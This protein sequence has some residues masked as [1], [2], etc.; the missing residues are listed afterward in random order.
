MADL[1]GGVLSCKSIGE[2]VRFIRAVSTRRQQ[3]PFGVEKVEGKSYDRLRREANERAISLLNSLADGAELTDEQRQTLAGYTGEGGI[4][5]SVSEYYTPKPVAEGVWEIMKLYGADVGNTLE[6]SAGTGVFNET[7]PVGTVMTATEISQI[8]GRINQL[9]HPEDSVQ[10][11]PFEQLATS[12]PNDSF[13]HVVGNVPF[14]GRDNT[15]NLDKP[16]AEE[17]DMG[18]YFMLRML[19]KIKPGGFMCVIV[20]PSIVSGNNMKR[21]R[22]RLSRKA[23]FLGAHRLPTGTF[24]ANGTSTVVDV[25]LM[26]KHP[27]D[28]A[29][30]IAQAEENTLEAANV[31]WSTFITGKWFERDG[32]RFVH[33]TQEQGFQGRIEVRA[34]GQIDN[35]ALKAKL[36]HRFDS[37]ID[38]SMLDVDEPSPTA[39]VIDDG[40]MRLINGVW[41]KFAGGH[42]IEADAGKELVI[43]S[44]SY[45]ADSWEAL[46][47]NLTTAE[48]RLA[49]TFSQMA[50]VRQQYTNSLSEDMVQLVDWIDSQPEKFRERLYRGAMIGRMLI[51]YQDM[52]AAGYSPTDIEQRRLSLVSKLQAEIDRFG[53]PGRGSIAKLSGSGARAWFAFRG[54]IKLDGSISDELTG[55]LITHD[56]SASYDSTSHQDTLRHLYSDLTRDPIQLDDFRQAFT[57]DLPASDDELLDLLANTPGI[58]VSPYGGIVPFA[59][60]TSGDISEIVAP[61]L[62]FLSKLPDGAVKNNV[63]NQ[64][65]AIEEKRIKTPAENIRF[66]LNSR[67]FDRSVILEFLKDNGYP[68]L[69]YVQSVQL[70]GDEMIS[71]TYHGGDG[72]FV[73]HRYGVVQRKD[74]ETGEIRYEWD[75]KSGDNATG[76][77]AQLEKY[78]N[79]ARIG[80]KDGATANGYREQMALLEDQFNKWIKTHDRYDDLVAKY[81]EVF[82]SNIPYEHSGDSLE[83][84]GISGKRQPFDYQN[85]E[86]R[87]LSEDGR[88][89]LGFGTGLGKTTTA[90]ALEAFNFENGRSTRTAYVVPK[91]VLEN[92]YYETKEFLSEQAFNNYLFI[93]LDVLMDGDQIRQVPVLD[94]NGKQVIGDDG[95]PVMRDGLKLADEAT[96]T[97]RMNA[98]PHSNYRAVV[99]TKEQYAR[100]PL[101][102]ETVDEHAEDMLYDF[103]AAG[104]VASAMESDS[105][106]KE[107][108]RRRVL[109]EHS[110]TG[111]EKA[112]K[113]PYFED[114]GFDSVIADEGHNY[115]NSYKNGREASQLAYLPTSAVAQS[116]R[117][118]AIKNAYLM[119]KNGGRGPVLL[120]A[121]PV[122]NTPIDA[123]NMLSHVLPKEFWQKMGI[124]GP[125]DFVKF[126]GKTRLE[127]VQK[128]SG[129]VEEKMAL[130]GFENLDA[131]RGIFHR[132]T[133]LKTAEDVKDTVEIP[134]LDERQQDAPLTDEQ[135]A[136]YEDLRK[137]AE[138]A[139]N[140]DKGMATIV[141]EDGT[142]TQE[143]TRPI[144]SIIR[145]MDRVCTDMDLYHRRITYRFL[146]EYADAVQ[147]LADDLP[148][149]A[150]SEDDDSTDSVTQQA[151]YSLIDKGDFIQL[152]VPEAFEPEVNKRLAKFGI[153]ERTVTH[154]ITPKYAKLIATLKE[155]LPDGKQIIFTDEKT[156]HQKLKRIICNALN[157]DPSQVGI[158]N[159]QTVADAGKSGKKLKAVKPPKDLPDEPT[160]A[161]LAKY[162]EQ[163][164]QYDA[165]IAQQNEISL[166]GLEKIAA[167]YQEGRTP[168]IICNKKAEVGINL[169]RG[170]SDIH[171]LTLPWTPASIAQRNGRGARVGSNR[172]SVRVHYYCGKGSF[173]EY[174]L[175]TLKRKAGWISDILR[176]DKSEMENADA[177][178]M[179]EM[180]MYTAKDDGERLSM[181]Q[182]QMDK[183]K[184]AQLAR[185]KEQANYDLQNYIKAQHAAGEDVEALTAE[186][187]KN[188][189]ALE[190]ATE[191]VAK[192]RELALKQAEYNEDWKTRWGSVYSSD[193]A[194]L[195]QYRTSLKYSIRSKADITATITKYEKLLSRTQKASTDIK[196]LRPLVE[197]AMS[198]GLVDIDPDLINHA[199]DFLVIGDR[200]WRV[201]QYYDQNGD[202]FRIK[203]LDFDSQ[204]ATIEVVYSLKGTKAGSWP[205]SL[206]TQQVDVTPDEE[207]VMLKI[208]GG[209]SI[210][211]INALISRD[212]FYRFQQRGMI[213]ISD[214]YAVVSSD[215]G[216]RLDFVGTEGI[217]N[218]VYPDRTDGALKTAIAK[219]ILGYIAEEKPYKFR[220]ADSFLTEL[221]G[222]NYLDVITSY[223]ESLSP[224]DI[225]ERI[226]VEIARLPEKSPEG[227][228]RN[229]DSELEVANAIFNSHSFSASSYELG[230]SAFGGISAY[231]NKNEIKAAIDAANV[232]IADERQAN[233]EHAVQAL[234]QSWVTAIK[235]AVATG[236]I[237]PAISRVV[238]DGAKFM[239]A[240]SNGSMPMPTAYG[241]TTNHPTYN[242]VSMFA[243]LVILGLVDITEVTPSLLSARKNYLDVLIRVADS[244]KARTNEQKEA[245]AD[246][247]NLALG[248]I[249]EE[250]IAA[251]NAKQED[252]AAEQGDATS[253]AQALGLNFRISTADL[254]MMYSPKF[255]AGEVFGLQEA[256]GQKGVLFRAK[257]E[258]K[259]KFGARWLPAKAKNSDFP[260]NWWILETKH[261]AADVLAVV[262]QYA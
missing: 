118:M 129:E 140:A 114:M 69:H 50:N 106:R 200:Q 156:Q 257:D 161:Q 245:D 99:F 33:G 230:T 242:L 240:Y 51:E 175:K 30:K 225:Q 155:C 119:K 70:E 174:R 158:L 81:N 144:F 166:G 73:G 113:Y 98:I 147:K 8:S 182:V 14:G 21:L 234:V 229:G 176:S 255:A 23:E 54:A 160:E 208:S 80:G 25:V 26:R 198:K 28:M 223:G 61:K 171:H 6:P 201:G 65:A 71:E 173:D 157:I 66:K 105:H 9:L 67:W 228:T 7:K 103:V 19:D 48:G 52:K 188:K 39:D 12:T 117:D 131:L 41:H 79:G 261:N 169:H 43:D 133:T 138:A 193:R 183:A 101:R 92:W 238:N 64:L 95:E 152:Q 204:R 220:G 46:Q 172:A 187:E 136:A 120:T 207:A 215:Q 143:K 165:Y 35:L 178:D 32:R 55:K 148:K 78:L 199:K 224:E 5:G 107:A 63:L 135:L 108:A 151:Q 74:K 112:E 250:E 241:M 141:G 100:I 17:T 194:L 177:N 159:A 243:D 24:D 189:A 47:R 29:E 247:I 56:A 57:G 258:L 10:V 85:S 190:K 134:E 3:V 90:L 226:A 222:S 209:V 163:M 15:R 124:F 102:N 77:P 237:T 244:L 206:L 137:Q 164:A 248:T 76:F 197:D 256:S 58:A 219:W 86:V 115:R 179:I 214:G 170:T 216:Y 132:W 233:L 2:I 31:L 45:G 27:K 186:L 116:A 231:S 260:G 37:R 62:A 195:S 121:T 184:A 252:I 202:I 22:L 42:W 38:W 232:R 142:I 210:A 109:S 49:M 180:Q 212:D 146:P 34:D 259:E 1:T 162:N 13:D 59:R 191:E 36:I 44:T 139:A 153:D 149:Q 246:R 196:R 127:T 145:D 53:N 185:Q 181:M 211:D 227:T 16:Y 150:T 4:G 154:P 235:G 20:P 18:S 167:D 249:T 221:F 126:F 75:K 89:I 123:Y 88:G 130:V 254:K 205:V 218:A 82:N 251:R 97:A 125:D 203:A 94:E 128:I 217:N 253:T 93:G 40:E 239:D 96:I 192:Y 84:A 262:K 104:R 236:K 168:I 60:A 91:S 72:L 11:S 87:R 111:T 122:V 213:T 68:D 83:L 110:D